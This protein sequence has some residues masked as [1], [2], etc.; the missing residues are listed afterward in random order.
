ML[1]SLFCE[2]GRR[3]SCQ[4]VKEFKL[5]YHRDLWQIMRFLCFGSLDELP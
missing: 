2:T 4:L 1:A 3:D 5:S